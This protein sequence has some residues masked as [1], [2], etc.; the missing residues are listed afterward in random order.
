[1]RPWFIAGL[2]SLPLSGFGAQSPNPM[3]AG[4]VTCSQ[5]LTLLGTHEGDNLEAW[6]AGRIAA[7][8][9][10]SFHAELRKITLT[11]F[12]QHLRDLCTRSDP[13]IDLFSGSA[14]LAAVYQK[15]RQR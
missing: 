2:L 1:M 9:P 14:F 3:S 10:V 7:I 15:A 8:V 11:E 6:V 4:D 12:K 13:Q 5:Y